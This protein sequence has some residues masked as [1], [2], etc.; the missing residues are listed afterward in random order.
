MI[1]KNENKN[2]VKNLNN[3]MDFSTKKSKILSSKTIDTTKISK[4]HCN[5]NMKE[6][7]KKSIISN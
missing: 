5:E 3:Q 4:D 6:L 2:A 1:S 7:T